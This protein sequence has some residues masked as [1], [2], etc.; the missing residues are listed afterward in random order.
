MLR[1]ANNL[2]ISYRVITFKFFEECKEVYKFIYLKSAWFQKEVRDNINWTFS[3]CQA[4]YQ[5]L[6]VNHLMR[7][8]N[9]S[10]Q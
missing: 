10:V 7:M 3:L 4:L 8:W 9:S 5:M 1:L 2:N 6:C